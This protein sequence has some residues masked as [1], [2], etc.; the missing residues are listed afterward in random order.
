MIIIFISPSIGVRGDAGIAMLYGTLFFESIIFPSIV[1]LGMKG[2]GRH[3]KQGS[4][5]IIAGVIGGAVV[6][7]ILGAVS[8]IR[9]SNTAYAMSVPLFFFVLAWSFG[10]CVNFVESYRAPIDAMGVDVAVVEGPG[11]AV[12]EEI[13]EGSDLEREKKVKG[14]VFAEKV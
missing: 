7:P 5:F 11:S 13:L 12:V 10:W 2:L 14:D 9:G 1:A 4:G 8:D 3:S 6:P